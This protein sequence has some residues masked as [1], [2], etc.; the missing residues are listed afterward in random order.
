MKL[1]IASLESPEF[2]RSKFLYP[3]REQYHPDYNTVEDKEF[4][5]ERLVVDNCHCRRCFF[6]SCNLVYSGGLFGFDECQF[7]AQTFLSLTGSAARAVAL[8]QSITMTDDT[9][10]PD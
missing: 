5:G 7:D 1:D 4:E 8:W 6:R 2:V 10:E 9:Y 3:G